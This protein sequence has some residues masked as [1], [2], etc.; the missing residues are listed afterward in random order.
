MAVKKKI[1]GFWEMRR[2]RTTTRQRKDSTE[3]PV[4]GTLMVGPV[5]VPVLLGPE[6]E[7]GEEG[8]DQKENGHNWDYST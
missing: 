3:R 4:P 5:R 7:H 1:W 2:R 8:R 6:R